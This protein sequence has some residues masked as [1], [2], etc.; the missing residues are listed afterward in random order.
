MFFE[1][2]LRF[3]QW[4]IFDAIDYIALL[5]G[6]KGSGEGLAQKERSRQSLSL[7]RDDL[8]HRKGGDGVKKSKGKGNRFPEKKR[9]KSHF[10]GQ[11]GGRKKKPFPFLPPTLPFF[12]TE[13]G[14]EIPR[15]LYRTA[16]FLDFS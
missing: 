4:N 7:K 5:W 12:G 1:V 3:L 13:K 2:F 8:Y 14:M 15:L 16:G 6:K 10:R 11:N 9:R